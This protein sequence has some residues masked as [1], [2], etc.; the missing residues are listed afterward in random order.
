MILI[1]KCSVCNE[2]IEIRVKKEDY[3]NFINGEHPQNAMPYLT[4]DEREFL[5][6]GICGICFDKIFEEC[7]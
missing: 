1:K 3:E 6:S 4:A 5:I 2:N 7:D